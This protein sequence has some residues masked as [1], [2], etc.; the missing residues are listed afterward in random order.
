MSVGVLNSMRSTSMCVRAPRSVHGERHAP[1]GAPG[2]SNRNACVPDSRAGCRA[3]ESKVGLQLEAATVAVSGLEA[4]RTHSLPI[5][6]GVSITR[7]TFAAA[8]VRSSAGAKREHGSWRTPAF[9]LI[10][11]C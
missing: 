10:F 7:A 8:E 4:L 1:R 2:K 5:K 11:V 6:M 3:R 9:A